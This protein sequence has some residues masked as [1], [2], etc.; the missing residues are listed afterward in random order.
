[1]PIQLKCNFCDDV[2]HINKERNHHILQNHSRHKFKCK[3]YGKNFKT[4]NGHYKC[5]SRH[6][7][8]CFHCCKFDNSFSFKSDLKQHAVVHKKSQQIKCLKCSRTFTTVN[9]MRQHLA[10]HDNKDK[11]PCEMCNFKTN[12]PYLLDQHVRGKHG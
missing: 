3:Q 4:D 2:F 12:S 8:K 9:S 1:M 11:F 7:E 6:Q 5:K 10:M